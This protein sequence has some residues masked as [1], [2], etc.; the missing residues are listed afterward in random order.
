MTYKT[1][2]DKT[3]GELKKVRPGETLP[4]SLAKLPVSIDITD[5]VALRNLAMTELV[6]IVSANAGDIKGIAAVR[7]L[8]DRSEGRTSQTVELSQTVE[9]KLSLEEAAKRI[10]FAIN[11]AAAKGVVLDGEFARLTAPQPASEQ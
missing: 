7:E 2:L 4:Q 5:K 6:A 8:L 1:V 11:A 9:V 3:T 10:A